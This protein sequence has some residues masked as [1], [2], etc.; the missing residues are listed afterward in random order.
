[1]LTVRQLFGNNFLSEMCNDVF[2]GMKGDLAMNRIQQ[3]LLAFSVAIVAFTGC[4][5]TPQGPIVIQKKGTEQMLEKAQTSPEA[6]ASSI[7]I[8]E[9]TEAPEEYKY[10][11]DYTDAKLRIEIDATVE[12]P[13]AES[14]PIVRVVP[15]DF[16][17]QLV[18]RLFD[19]LCAGKD[20]YDTSQRMTK[21]EIE[22]QILLWK[23]TRQSVDYADIPL[24][25]SEIDVWIELLEREYPHAPETRESLPVDGNLYAIPVTDPEGNAHATRMGISARSEGDEHYVEFIVKNNYELAEP[26]VYELP[27][28]AEVVIPVERGSL[29]WFVNSAIYENNWEWSKI[30]RITDKTSVPAEAQNK[31]LLTPSQAQEQADELL[32]NTSMGISQMYLYAD[33]K[34]QQSANYFGYKLLYTRQ[35]NGVGCAITNAST[36]GGD[37]YAPSWAYEQLSILI[38]DDG[39]VELNWISP[40]S[41]TET[42]VNDAQLLSFPEIMD[43]YEKIIAVTYSPITKQDGLVNTALK[44]NK[45]Q[46]GL[47]RVSE[48][49]NIDAGL[50]IPTWSF[51][52]EVVTETTDG[53]KD[54]L[55]TGSDCLL[56]INAI[57]GSIIDLAKGY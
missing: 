56:T 29:L 35:I 55:H 27:G 5:A 32:K 13:D 17:A 49:N 6:E 31:L 23:Q 26:I 10:K 54:V 30:A 2:I 20:M 1:M 50:L 8:K 25:E 21:S 4:Q 47:Q 9:R 33:S 39:I 28:N 53:A 38:T 45:I 19:V 46:L 24:G 7:S 44:V 18:Q 3:L 14:M 48:M 22:K 43:V 37:K 51:Y 16:D 40:I 57:D 12:L 42:L 15:A 11:N 36:G 52:G 41:V 34:N